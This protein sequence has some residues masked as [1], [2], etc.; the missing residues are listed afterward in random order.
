M[1]L[2][3]DIIRPLSLAGRLFLRFWPQLLLLAT[4]GILL[5]DLL[6]DLAVRAGLENALAGMVVLS[7]VVL[8]KLVIIVMMFAVLRPAMVG[9]AALAE[10]PAAA[11]GNKYRATHIV[12]VTAVA[13]LPFF[14]YYA[15]WG[16]LGDTVRE[17]SRMALARVPFGE[18]ANFLDLLQA[19]WLVVS[20]FACWL[21]RWFARYMNR[22]A[23]VPYWRFLV[24][25]C[26]ATWVFIGLYGISIYTNQL[27]ESLGAGA[28]AASSFFI[29][30]ARAAP[31]FTPVE[32]A[33][34]DFWTQVRSL[35]FFGLLPLVWLVMTAIIYGYELSKPV[36]GPAGDMGGGATW[37]KW[38]GDFIGHYIGGYRSRYGPVWRCVRLTMTAGTATLLTFMIAYQLIAWG[39]AWAWVGATRAIGAHDLTTWQMLASPLTLLFGSPSDLSGGILLDA[40]RICLLAAVLD[41]AII[42]GRR[43]GG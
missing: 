15:A 28:F 9:L 5:H 11:S 17:Y 19:R 8:A 36:A 16:F 27:I 43:Q 26:D 18:S 37:R 31:G 40:I 10:E 34:P 29:G 2:A 23:T 32:L 38:F 12:G 41:Y 42:S 39:G 24:V 6:L 21:V 20:I 22:R 35:F 14:V 25:A 7:F 3:L 30:E 4:I 1:S 13:I 33:A